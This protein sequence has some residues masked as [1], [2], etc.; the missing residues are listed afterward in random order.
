MAWRAPTFLDEL[1][2]L[3]NLER[4]LCGIAQL[5]YPKEAKVVERWLVEMNASTRSHAWK[6][7]L[8]LWCALVDPKTDERGAPARF[9]HQNEDCKAHVRPFLERV[10]LLRELTPLL[11]PA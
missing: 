7:A 3:S 9:L 4:L 8:H 5:A 2:D 1:P 11:G 6:A 10:G